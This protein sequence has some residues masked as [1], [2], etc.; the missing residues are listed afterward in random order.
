MT[1]VSF[2][3]RLPL[4]AILSFFLGENYS[5]NLWWEFVGSVS[6]EDSVDSESVAGWEDCRRSSGED[7]VGIDNNFSS[8]F[9]SDA[10]LQCQTFLFVFFLILCI[11]FEINQ[12]LLFAHVLVC[13]VADFS[14]LDSKIIPNLGFTLFCFVYFHSCIELCFAAGVIVGVKDLR[15]LVVDVV[16]SD[17]FLS[18]LS[19]YFII[20]HIYTLNY[21][22]FLNIFC[23][24]VFGNRG[25]FLESTKGFLN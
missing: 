16:V 15:S 7:E 12:Q 2:L 5:G 1:S 6:V 19:Y 3:L 25:N 24:I 13:V 9:L 11:Y 23:E 10:T 4:S 22:A 8:F 17:Y 18:I 21:F 20:I 14:K